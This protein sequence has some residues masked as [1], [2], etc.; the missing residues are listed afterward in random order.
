MVGMASFSPQLH[1]ANMQE[2]V[3][4][5]IT[6]KIEALKKEIEIV[7]SYEARTQ[8]QGALLTETLRRA[9]RGDQV[10]RLQRVLGA[11]ETGIFEEETEQAVVAYQKQY[12][13]I[14]DGIVGRKT[15]A[16]LNEKFF[17]QETLGSPSIA[18]RLSV[19]L[20]PV[21][22]TQGFIISGGSAHSAG[23]QALAPVLKI[24][25]EVIKGARA[26]V[27]SLTLRQLGVGGDAVLD[28]A[29]LYESDEIT[30]IAYASPQIL[31]TVSF[32]R[33]DKSPLFTVEGTKIIH[34]LIDVNKQVR[35]GEKLVFSVNTASDILT[36]ASLVE[37]V[38]PLRGPEVTVVTVSDLGRLQVIP[39]NIT[40]LASAGSMNVDLF[41]FDL[42]AFNQDIDVRMLRLTQDGVLHDKDITN[43]RLED[44]G[45]LLLGLGT[46]KDGS[47]DFGNG[48]SSFLVI[49]RGTIKSLTLKGDIIGGAEKTFE[50]GIIKSF[51]LLAHDKNYNVRIRPDTGIPGV[52]RGVESNP[53]TVGASSLVVK[54]SMISP[55]GIMLL[56]SSMTLLGQFDLTGF[57]EDVLITNLRLA[58]DLDDDD[59]KGPVDIKDVM[60]FFD[61]TGVTMD[62][63]NLLD[64][65]VDGDHVYGEA[66]EGGFEEGVLTIKTSLILPQGVTK[67][68]SLF[69]TVGSSVNVTRPL[70]RGDA[71]TVVLPEHGIAWE[72]MKTHKAQT[73]PETML[74]AGTLRV[75][76]LLEQ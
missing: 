29:Y 45:G 49:P 8:V 71:L 26:H 32:G 34:V 1:A 51:D 67:T 27:S 16:I 42:A 24:K 14:A 57:G 46:M 68:L 13:L 61:G 50:F 19:S 3:I 7:R 56:G 9:S 10:L 18:P 64:G 65:S 73:S 69:A 47:L 12:N 33:Q 6:A 30:P 66:G 11:P 48:T 60:L 31:G 22:S 58:V 59:D 44:A 55:Q 35:W 2:Q 41:K 28:T 72:G 53:I 20:V 40:T 17:S 36:D 62:P 74:R 54:T 37:G 23:S 75:I 76:T 15:R 52:F 4:Q 5:E 21:N 25:F 63:V 38:F 70:M 39:K 43:V